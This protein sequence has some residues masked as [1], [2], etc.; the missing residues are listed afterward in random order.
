MNLQDFKKVVEVLEKNIFEKVKS[1]IYKEA[2]LVHEGVEIE[3]AFL[4]VLGRI[5]A[6]SEM[7]RIYY[8][9]EYEEILEEVG[10]YIKNKKSDK[11]YQK[12]IRN[13]FK[14]IFIFGERI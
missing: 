12:E 2:Y 5:P 6:D 4:E 14:D 13:T 7:D 1:G 3:D 11:L 9:E 8:S 10:E